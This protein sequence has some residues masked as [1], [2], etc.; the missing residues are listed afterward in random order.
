MRA[1]PARTGH[2]LL[3]RTSPSSAGVRLGYMIG[4][5][6]LVHEIDKVRPPHNVSVLNGEAA[7]FA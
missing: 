2:V 5:R 7:L 4:L 1:E 3:M 6:A